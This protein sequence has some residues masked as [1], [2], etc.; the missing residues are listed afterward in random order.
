MAKKKNQDTDDLADIKIDFG[1]IAIPEVNLAA[2]GGADVT[3]AR[4]RR[5]QTNRAMEPRPSEKNAPSIVQSQEL[6]L[7]EI[8]PNKGQ[9]PGVPKNPRV[10][11]DQKFRLLKKS[12]EEDP[13][14]LGLREILLYPYQGKNII[15]GGNMR[16]QALKD[17]GYTT[18][19]VKF[20]PA[21]FTAEKLRAI[22][23]KG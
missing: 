5:N 7:S 2:L 18:A 4:R 13:E 9:I 6:P 12:I 11:R 19:I 10:I 14:M 23:I 8:T 17:L 20:L 3:S 1:D 16:Y 15:I 22:V 21:D